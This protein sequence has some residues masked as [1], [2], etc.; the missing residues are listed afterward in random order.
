MTSAVEFGFDAV[1]DVPPKAKAKSRPADNESAEDLLAIEWADELGD[2]VVPAD[3]LI[4]RTLTRGAMSVIYG[5]S[6]TG[7]TFFCVDALAAV[8]RNAL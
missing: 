7:K 3:E 4:E 5:D 6:N 8:C 1:D 2:K